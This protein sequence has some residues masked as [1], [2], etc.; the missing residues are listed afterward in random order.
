MQVSLFPRSLKAPK[1]RQVRP[2]IEL[3]CVTKVLLDQLRQTVY[4]VALAALIKAMPKAAYVHQLPTVSLPTCRGHLT[5]SS[6]PCSSCHC[7]SAGSPCLTPRFARASS[8]RSS[9][10]RKLMSR[11]VRRR[12]AISSRSTLPA[13][14][15]S[16][17]RTAP[18]QRSQTRWVCNNLP[19]VMSLHIGKTESTG[20]RTQVSGCVTENCA[21]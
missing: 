17:Y 7:S 13:S 12:K 11:L 4:L 20:G 6:S 18:A 9:P 10:P 8:T 5:C 1:T 14:R 19:P 3:V 16:C 15:V 2:S 21:V